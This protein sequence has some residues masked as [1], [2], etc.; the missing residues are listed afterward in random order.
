[1]ECSTGEA[2]V[3]RIISALSAH[4]FFFFAYTG[5][6]RKEHHEP[7][8]QIMNQHQITVIQQ[9]ASLSIEGKISFGDVIRRLMEIGLERYHAD[10]TRHEISYYMPDGESIVVPV[11][12]PA[13]PIADEFSVKG[14]EAAVR[15]AQRGEIV[16]PEFLKQ[17]FAAGC[18]GYFVQISGRQVIYFGRRGEQHVE[19]F[20]SA[21]N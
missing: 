18:V 21:P 5:A 1:M 19:R 20:P 6:S 13:V 7:E 12:H 3:P 10:Y 15:R 11:H 17:T 2:P 8:R 9:C 4:H 16:Y 14:V